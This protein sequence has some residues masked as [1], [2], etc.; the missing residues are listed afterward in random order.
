MKIYT[1]TGDK[2]Q[3]QIYADKMVRMEKSADVLE[4]YGTLDEL[5]A[6]IGL[7]LSEDSDPIILSQQSLLLDIQKNL[8]QIGFAISATTSMDQN[9][10]SELEL[11]I[12]ELQASLP[13]QTHFLLPGG[14]KIAAQTHVCRTVARRAERR[15]VALI[16]DYPVPESCLSYVNRLSDYFF[17]LARK[18]NIHHQVKE[19]TV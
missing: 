6:H 15:L 11:R 4:C 1:K 3:T 14:H 13:A 18:I 2:G 9:A 8:F 19:T 16:S 5:N 7:L 12:D 17:I 10:V